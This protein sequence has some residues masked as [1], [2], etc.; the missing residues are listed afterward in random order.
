MK[1]GEDPETNHR[2]CAWLRSDATACFVHACVRACVR[3]CVRMC[4]CGCA[5]VCVCACVGG[6]VDPDTVHELRHAMRISP[7]NFES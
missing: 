5:R 7:N 3:V 1:T 2:L 6:C 4:V